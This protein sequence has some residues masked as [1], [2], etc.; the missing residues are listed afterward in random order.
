[1]VHDPIRAADT[2]AWLA[3][4]EMDLKAAAHELTAA[5]PFTADAV[6]HA[7]QA[8][9]KAMKGFLAWHDVPFRKTHDLAELGHQCA[10]V[11]RSLESL[12]IRAAGLTQYAWKF[13]YPGE[14]E[15]PSL[16]EAEASIALAREA[17]DAI[18]SVLPREPG[19]T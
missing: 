2:R 4:A 15:E 7:Q 8:A 11:D 18:V 14:P 12:L 10:G 16:E 1:M 6:F 19:L 3:K 17:F 5:P 13:R 9:E